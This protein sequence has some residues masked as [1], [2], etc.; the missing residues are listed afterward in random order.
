M[1][2]EAT[3]QELCTRMGVESVEDAFIVAVGRE[4]TSEGLAWFDGSSG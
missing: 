1:V 2:I 4:L 3:P